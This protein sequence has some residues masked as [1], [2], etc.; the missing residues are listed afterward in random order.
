MKKGQCTQEQIIRVLQE[1]E[2]G[3]KSVAAPLFNGIQNILPIE[4]FQ[5]LKVGDVLDDPVNNLKVWPAS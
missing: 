3:E 4:Y 2:R 1:A 5:S